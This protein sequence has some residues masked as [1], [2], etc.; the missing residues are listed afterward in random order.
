MRSGTSPFGVPGLVLGVAS[1]IVAV[2]GCVQAGIGAQLLRRF[3]RGNAS[4]TRRAGVPL[5][6]V[7]VL[8]PLHGDEPM[9]ER[10][11][12]SF[13]VQRYPEYQIVFGVQDAADQAIA[14]VRRLQARFPDRALD[15]VVSDVQHGPNRKIGNLIN[16]LPSARHEVLVVSDSDI[17]AEPGYLRA[18]AEALGGPGISLVTTLYGGLPSDA[19]WARRLAAAQVNHNFLPG[20]LM[21]RLLGRQDCLGATMAL[22]RTTLDRI[23]GLEMLAPHLA[24]D[25]ALGQLVRADGGDIAIADTMTR[26]TI[27]DR[28]LREVYAHELRWGRTV[29]SVEPVGYALSAMQLPLFWACVVVLSVP[30]AGWSWAVLA[31]VWLWRLFT[32][33]MIDRVV[34]AEPVLPALLLPLRDCISA[35]VMVNSF[36]GRTVAWRGHVI[37]LPARGGPT[38]RPARQA[39]MLPMM[40]PA[41]AIQPATVDPHALPRVSQR[42]AGPQ[43]MPQAVE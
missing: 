33:R 11:L 8:K 7:T 41:D 31:G 23:G 37:A 32:A 17:H 2:L 14:V 22:R 26:T 42:R 36:H 4:R 39:A 30:S 13:C 18:V 1:A 35:L 21:S 34:G 15:L 38:R 19:G 28:S 6:P 29:R 43:P 24:D 5:P 25:S 20:V 16:M 12:E 3:D 40:P 10:A 27:S 9:L